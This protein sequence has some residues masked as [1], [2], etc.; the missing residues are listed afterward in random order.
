MSNS[1]RMTVI[2]CARSAGASLE[3]LEAL[4]KRLP[5]GVEW[6]SVPCGAAVDDLLLLRALEAGAERV[7]VLVCN[8]DACRSMEGSRWAQ[9]RTAAARALLDEI[10]LGG[11]RV[12]L[13][14]IGPNMPM[15][16][17][18]EVEAFRLA[19]PEPAGAGTTESEGTRA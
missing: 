15:D 8:H 17:L 18:R 7:L 5:E 1:A 10:G 11:W 19:A 16:L 13:R 6:V 3:A 12:A 14:Q 2:G 9:K 4:G